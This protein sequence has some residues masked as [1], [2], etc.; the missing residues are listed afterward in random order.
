MLWETY[1]WDL[2]VPIISECFAT[3][4]G[5][6]SWA[7]LVSLWEGNQ[8]G[9]TV[10]SF[11]AEIRLLN[12]S[13]NSS[14]PIRTKMYL[15]TDMGNPTHIHQLRLCLLLSFPWRPASGPVFWTAST[16]AA[17]SY[18]WFPFKP[19]RN[20]LFRTNYTVL[21]LPVLS[22][23]QIHS[24]FKSHWLTQFCSV[25]IDACTVHFMYFFSSP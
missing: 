6:I 14:Y 24:Y 20:P 1:S 11:G 16:W 10:A 13:R 4:K 7:A 25:Q 17:E 21:Q 2:Q 18:H 15:Q 8:S 3:R 23:T 12:S 5:E 19:S 22:I 9:N